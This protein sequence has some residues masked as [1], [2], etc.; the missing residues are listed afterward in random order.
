VPDAP[1]SGQNVS[2]VLDVLEKRLAMAEAGEYPN[3]PIAS[4]LRPL[5]QL[6]KSDV[7]LRVGCADA[8]GWDTHAAQPATLNENL[9]HLGDA[10]AAFM[11]DLG[12]RAQEV[13]L[14]AA[15]EFGRT[16]RQNETLGTDHGHGS[17]ALV[18]GGA[19]QGGRVHG[20]W[21]GLADDQLYE[22]RDLA[23]TTDL[24]SVL[25][26]VAEAQL[27]ATEPG[28]L[29]PGFAGDPLAGLFG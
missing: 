3:N 20:T 12:P 8:G 13:V 22:G 21:P 15:T 27:D 7:G 23:V 14:V 1:E 19:V 17:V 2:A 29:F 16:V 10:V 4:A 28:S 24:R 26:A 25:A 11:L 6:I 9:R 18:A 5:A